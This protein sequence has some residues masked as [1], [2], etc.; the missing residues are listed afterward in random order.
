MPSSCG[1]VD[2]SI[3]PKYVTHIHTLD[4]F[5]GD[6]E[7]GRRSTF[8]VGLFELLE[9]FA[10]EEFKY[11]RR[12]GMKLLMPTYDERNATLFKMVFG[13]IPYEAKRN[14]YGSSQRGLTPKNLT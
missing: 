13:N 6:P 1:S 2:Q 7:Q 10:N 4:Q 14:T 3:I 12:D 11:V 9:D 8:S 5:V